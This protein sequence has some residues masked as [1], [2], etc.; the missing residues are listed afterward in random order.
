MHRPGAAA[1]DSGRRLFEYWMH[2]ACI[3]PLAHYRLAMAAMR[4][5]AEGGAGWRR[6]WPT[7]P[8]TAGCCAR[9]WRGSRR[10]GRSG[11]RTPH[12]EETARHLVELGRAKIALEHLYNTGHL[13]IC[14]R[15]NFQRV[16]D[17]RDRVLPAWVDRREPDADEAMRS[18]LEISSKALGMCTPA[19]V[20]H[21]FHAKQAD[22]RPLIDRLI[23]RGRLVTVTA[24]LADGAD[25]ELV[26]HRD[27]LPLLQRAAD[28]ELRPRRTTF[29][30]PFDS[31]FWASGRPAI[32]HGN[33]IVR[34]RRHVDN[35]PRHLRR[36]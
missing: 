27:N 10:T 26:V 7:T 19:Q 18:L 22:A 9:C 23:A 34:L 1:P 35:A 24:R 3:I 17:L 14:N 13:A 12:R 36:R 21:Y 6:R 31:L 11:P 28:G 16:Y 32:L 15:V 25:H 30:S 4:R 33:H 8:H 5:H 29:L 20:A 2:A